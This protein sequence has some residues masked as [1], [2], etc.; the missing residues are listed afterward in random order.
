M[1][2]ISI[3][4]GRPPRGRRTVLFTVAA[5]ALVT[6]L[7]PAPAL[8]QVPPPTLTGETFLG[9]PVLTNVTC[10]PA[11]TSTAT[12]TVTN[13]TASGPYPGTFSAT[14]TVTFGATVAVGAGYQPVT[15]LTETFTIT[16]AA[17]NVS[18][19]K[20]FTA[21]TGTRS[22]CNMPGDL[23]TR[24]FSAT[25]DALIEGTPQR[26][27]DQ[28]DSLV[29]IDDKTSM[30]NGVATF[31]ES[32]TSSLLATV[33]EVVPGPPSGCDQEGDMMGPY[34]CEREDGTR[35]LIPRVV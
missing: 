11:G 10:D 16:S 14:G 22:H 3:S 13:G 17:G 7:G 21:A 25:Y 32:F 28:G 27:T 6:A 8:A 5:G 30:P 9:T 12:F 15:G 23:T 34:H 33:P 26:Y 4:I 1:F 24:S 18:G 19:S 2:G 35:P 31:Y 20:K 29:S